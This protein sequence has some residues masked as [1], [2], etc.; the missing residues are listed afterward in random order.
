MTL[1]QT[2]EDKEIPIQGVYL[3]ANHQDN[4]KREKEESYTEHKLSKSN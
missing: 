2:S 1:R 4:R 3:F